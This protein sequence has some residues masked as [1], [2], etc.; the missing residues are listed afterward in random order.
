[1]AEEIQLPFITGR[2]KAAAILIV[3][4]ADIS[5]EVFKHLK[6]EEIEAITREIA[7]IRKI[8]HSQK[9]LLLQEF[10]SLMMAQEFIIQGGVEYARALLIQAL[11][12]ERAN[13]FINE[14]SGIKKEPF[15]FLKKMDMKQILLSIQ[16]EHPQTIAL[17]MGHLTPDKAAA[18][19][20]QL[21]P[22]VQVDVSRRLALMS[23]SSPDALGRVE[24]MLAARMEGGVAVETGG[25]DVGGIMAIVDLLN[26]GD[27]ELEQTILDGIAEQDPELAEE[28]K[29]R[30]FTFDD[31]VKLD[32]RSAQRVLREVDIRDLALSMKGGSENARNMVFRN[33]PKRA[34][35]MLREEID[36]LGPVRA[37]DVEASQEKIVNVIRQLEDS[38]EIIINRGGGG[39]GGGMIT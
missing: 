25:K 34:A 17:V 26:Q 10:Y 28:I 27:R 36:F 11:G 14:V 37:Q 13:A 20:T 12:E 29:K 7:K 18:L 38:G 31:I 39:G 35:A 32:D 21:P 4:G 23:S 19:I 9:I 33:M 6:E 22:E 3:L 30:L 5:S 16:H 1:M 15:D 8:T 2:Q 24:S